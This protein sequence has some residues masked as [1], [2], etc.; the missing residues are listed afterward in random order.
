MPAEL[1]EEAVD[2]ARV[3]GVHAV[4][5]EL[6]LNYRNLKS[7]LS[8]DDRVCQSNTPKPPVF[9]ELEKEQ[10]LGVSESK[11][12]T[13]ELTNS[14]G[15]KLTVHLPGQQALDVSSLVSSFFQKSP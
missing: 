8:E 3:H 11:E 15:G 5:Y 13:L 6:G 12:I 7:R 10:I 2:I 14:D 4:S 9:V 1:W